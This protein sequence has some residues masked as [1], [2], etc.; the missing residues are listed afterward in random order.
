MVVPLAIER[1]GSRGREW[2]RFGYQVNLGQVRGMN[3]A[4]CIHLP[5]RGRNSEGLA[6][7]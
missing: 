6:R 2:E 1:R 5:F 4:P 7:L 3:E